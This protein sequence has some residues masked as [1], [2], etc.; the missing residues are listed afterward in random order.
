MARYAMKLYKTN[1][2]GSKDTSFLIALKSVLG[3]EGLRIL[4]LNM[5]DDNMHNTK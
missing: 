1:I 2:A 4:S 3:S 5:D